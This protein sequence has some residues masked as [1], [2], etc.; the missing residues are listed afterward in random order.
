MDQAVLQVAVEDLEQKRIQLSEQ[1]L[2]TEAAIRAL[3]EICE[4]D[5][6]SSSRDLHYSYEKCKY[7]GIEQKA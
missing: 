3:Q 4:H 1:Q 6:E 5:F 2:K 7:C